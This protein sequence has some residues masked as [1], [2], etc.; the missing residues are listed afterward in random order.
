MGIALLKSLPHLFESAHLNHGENAVESMFEVIITYDDYEKEFLNAFLQTWAYRH[1][2]SA[3][4]IDKFVKQCGTAY[5]RHLSLMC[6]LDYMEAA[7][8]SKHW[9][10]LELIYSNIFKRNIRIAQWDGFA[11]DNRGIINPHYGVIHYQYYQKILA[12]LNSYFSDYETLPKPEDSKRT[13]DELLQEFERIVN[14][15][16]T[17]TFF[18]STI[19]SRAFDQRM[20]NFLSS[21]DQILSTYEPK[22]IDSDHGSVKTDEPESVDYLQYGPDRYLPGFY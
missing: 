5:I 8:A 10:E 19:D 12:A 14:A 13:F 18:S 20:Y 7:T 22:T 11:L 6:M 3:G 15:S 4:F 16:K 9:K 17:L 2:F 21:T 1:Y